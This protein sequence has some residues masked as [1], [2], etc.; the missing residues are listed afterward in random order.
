MIIKSAQLKKKDLDGIYQFKT[1]IPGKDFV[2]IVA[3]TFFILWSV[4]PQFCQR[5]I[6]DERT[7]IYLPKITNNNNNAFISI[8][9]I[10]T[11]IIVRGSTSLTKGEEIRTCIKDIIK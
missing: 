8:A 2:K 1:S 5:L 9:P 4:D 3:K 6:E 7:D 10:Q 11:N